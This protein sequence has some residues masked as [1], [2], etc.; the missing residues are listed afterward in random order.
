V[1]EATLREKETIM[2]CMEHNCSVCK[3][4]WFDNQPSGTCPKCGSYEVSS[5]FDEDPEPAYAGDEEPEKE[6]H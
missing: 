2:A 1:T 3:E 4:M 5:F 6:I